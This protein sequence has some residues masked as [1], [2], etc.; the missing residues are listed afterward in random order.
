MATKK[1]SFFFSA[2][3]FFVCLHSNVY[4]NVKIMDL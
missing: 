3:Y 1:T 4:Y 2:L